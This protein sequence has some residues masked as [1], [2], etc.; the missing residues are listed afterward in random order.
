ME[1]HMLKYLSYA[2]YSV[3]LLTA[4]SCVQPPPQPPGQAFLVDLQS[5]S[6]SSVDGFLN[7]END[8]IQV[9]YVFW[10][11]DGLVG[12]YVHNKLKQPFYI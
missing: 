8:S 5:P 2:I 10:A 12:M 6:C 3:L 1:I 4:V 7:Y 11:E 9:A